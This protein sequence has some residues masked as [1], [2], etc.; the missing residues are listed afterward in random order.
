F[1]KAFGGDKVYFEALDK[2]RPCCEYVFER[3]HG[4]QIG[5]FLAKFDPAYSV[6][7]CPDAIR[8]AARES[9]LYYFKED[10]VVYIEAI[11]ETVFLGMPF[12]EIFESAIRGFIEAEKISG[13]KVHAVLIPSLW[14]HLDLLLKDEKGGFEAVQ[15]RAFFNTARMSSAEMRAWISKKAEA[16]E[17]LFP[18]LERQEWKKVFLREFE[19]DPAVTLES[20]KYNERF[21]QEVKFLVSV[22][23]FIM[24]KAQ[25]AA[26]E[27]VRG[28]IA[29][30]DKW[31]REQPE[32]A[33]RLVGLDTV[34]SEVGYIFWVLRPALRFAAKH[35]FKVR[36][37]LGETWPRGDI[38][39][40]L[41]R[42][43]DGLRSGI[44]MR[45]GHG[46]AA[47]I[48][49]DI[50]RK[51]GL[52]SEEE[53]KQIGALQK[54]IS[55]LANRNRVEIIG[56]P[57]SNQLIMPDCVGTYAEYP[58]QAF[59]KAFNHF[60]ISTDDPGIFKGNR[61]SEQLAR[62]WLANPNLREEIIFNL[63]SPR[64][65]STGGAANIGC[66][67]GLPIMATVQ[68]VEMIGKA[69]AFLEAIKDAEK[70]AASDIPILIEGETGVGKEVL[71][72][73][74]HDKSRRKDGPFI[75]VDVS[76]LGEELV[77]SELFGHTRGA[78][79]GA[80]RDKK[81]LVEQADGGTLFLDEI[82]NLSPATQNKLLHVL[83]KGGEFS[84]VGSTQARRSNFRLITANNRGNLRNVAGGKLFSLGLYHRVNDM[85]IWLPPLR[86]RRKDIPLLVEYFQRLLAEEHRV[87]VR[88]LSKSAM[89]ELM[90]RDWP[91]NIRELFNV[92]RRIF[93]FGEDVGLSR[94][95]PEVE[96][97]LQ[98]Q[99]P[100]I[101]FIDDS[102]RE[103]VL[104][105][106]SLALR[107]VVR[108]AEIVASTN[109]PVLI[110]GETG[111]GKSLLAG[112]IHSVSPRRNG[113]FVD[114]SVSD[115]PES[116][117][118]SEMF[119]HTKGSFTGAEN[120]KDGL[121]E[122]AN[123]GTLVIDGITSLNFSLQ[124]KL[125]R[126]FQ[127]KRFRRVGESKERYSDFRLITLVSGESM[128]ELVA[129][130]EFREDLFYR[131]G[132]IDI[133]LLPLRERKEDL[134]ALIDYYLRVYFGQ[135]GFPQRAPSAEMMRILLNYEWPGNVR[136]LSSIVHRLVLLD[137]TGE[138]YV[139]KDICPQAL[140]EASR[141]DSQLGC[142]FG[143][144]A[145]ALSGLI[146]LVSMGYGFWD[147]AL[148]EAGP[149]MATTS[150]GVSLNKTAD[151]DDYIR[152]LRKLIASRYFC[153]EHYQKLAQRQRKATRHPVEFLEKHPGIL[154]RLEQDYR[155]K[156]VLR[157]RIL[158]S[159]VT[160][161]DRINIFLTLD[162]VGAIIGPVDNERSIRQ[163]V[164]KI[165]DKIFEII[166]SYAGT[167]AE[168][169]EAY[170]RNFKGGKS[171][172]KYLFPE[173]E[174]LVLAEILAENHYSLVSASYSLGI[175]MGRSSV[176]MRRARALGLTRRF[177]KQVR[178]DRIVINRILANGTEDSSSQLGCFFGL[179]VMGVTCADET[180]EI[181]FSD[182][183]THLFVGE[184]KHY[185]AYRKL[186][187]HPV[188][189]NREIIGTHF[190]VWAPNAQSV[191]IVGDFNDW[192]QDRNYMVRQ[193]S[194][195][196]WQLFI[197][198]VSIG[199]R[200]KYAIKGSDGLVRLKNDPYG[201]FT[202]FPTSDN[203]MSTASIIWDLSY[204]W[205]D[206]AWMDKR[207]QTQALD[208]PVSI[209][210]VH[211]GSWRRNEDG[212]WLTYREIAEQLA[213]YVLQMGFTHVELLP[214][215]EYS[216]GGSWGYQVSNYFS[217]TSRFGQ[218]QDF[219]YFVDYLH[220][221]GI[222]VI[223]DWVPAHFPEDVHGL[224]KFDGTELYSHEYDVF[225]R[226]P[227][228]GTRI[229][230]YGR[231]EVKS[232]LI[233]NALFWLEK[234]H[235]DGLRVD[236][237]ASMLY[238][239]Y[240]RSKA[241][242]EF[243]WKI[244]G[245]NV[246]VAAM[247][248]LK[249]FNRVAHANF[250]GILTIA[251]EST[252]WAGVSRPTYID[253]LGFSMKWAMGWMHDVLEYMRLDPVHRKFHQN[254]ITF[255]LLYAF[256]ENF[257][258][259]LSHDEVVHG[260]K[261]LLEKMPG[262]QWQRFANLRLLFGNMFTMPGKN[263]IFMGG[264]F[265]QF[266]EW[267]HNLG[268]DWRVLDYPEHQ[269]LKRWVRD[270]NTLYR[271]EGAL[272]QRDF[273]QH[274]FNWIDCKDR[275]NSVISFVRQGNSPDEA[276]AIV[277]NFTPEPRENYRVGLPSSGIWQ[278]VLNSDAAIYG[279]SNMGNAG[280]VLAEGE[281]FH[282]QPYSVRL[283]LPPLSVVIFKN[284]RVN[285][286]VSS[287]NSLGCFFGLPI[288]AMADIQN[289]SA[290]SPHTDFDTLPLDPLIREA[291][292]AMHPA[293]K[294]DADWS[295]FNQI[296]VELKTRKN[297]Q[298]IV[299][300]GHR[301]VQ[302][303][304]TVDYFSKEQDLYDFFWYSADTLEARNEAY[305]VSALV[306][307]V[308]QHVS[309]GIALVIKER[310]K[311]FVR[312]IV[313]DNGAG[314]KNRKARISILEAIKDRHSP[315]EGGE[316]G[317]D[318]TNAVGRSAD[319]S[320]IE[321]PTESA[322]ISLVPSSAGDAEIVPNVRWVG[323]NDKKFGTTITGYFYRGAADQN[324][325]RE[326]LIESLKR[327]HEHFEITEVQVSEY[328]QLIKE[329]VRLI[330][331]HVMHDVIAAS[332]FAE[333]IYSSLKFN[334]QDNRQVVVARVGS[335][336]VIG[337]RIV[338]IL[339]DG[340]KD[341]LS[342]VSPEIETEG[343]LAGVVA[344]SM[345][346]KL[347]GIGTRLFERSLD[348]L[349][350]QN[351]RYYLATVHEDNA[352]A[353]VMLEN[354]SK[355]MGIGLLSLGISL[356]GE[357]V[358]NLFLLD[359][360]PDR[361]MPAFLLSQSTIVYDP[362]HPQTTHASADDSP[363]GCFFGMPV[364]AVTNS[365]DRQENIGGWQP[366]AELDGKVLINTETGRIKFASDEPDKD[367]IVDI[368]FEL[369]SV[370][371]GETEGNKRHGL[372]QGRVDLGINQ[373]NNKGRN[374][375]APKA[376]EKLWAQ[377][378]N[379]IKS[380]KR[381]LIITSTLSRSKDTA[382]PFIVLVKEA[383]GAEF[384]VVEE[385]LAD[386]LSFGIWENLTPDEIGD[387][388]GEQERER[389]ARY[390]RRD[391]TVR[392]RNG[393]S[394][395][396]LLIRRRKLWEKI[397]E[398]SPDIAVIF[399][400]GSAS[401]A[402]RILLGD[403]F[404]IDETGQLTWGSHRMPPNAEPVLFKASAR[405]GADL[406]RKTRDN[407]LGCFFG[408]PIMAMTEATQRFD[409]DILIAEAQRQWRESCEPKLIHTQTINDIR[410]MYGIKEYEELIELLADRFEGYRIA[411]AGKLAYFLRLFGYTRLFIGVYHGNYTLVLQALRGGSDR[412]I[413]A[414][415]EVAVRHY[416][417][418]MRHSAYSR[419]L[420]YEDQV[421]EFVSD[422]TEILEQKRKSGDHN[423]K[424]LIPG[425]ALAQDILS[426][427]WVLEHRIKPD[428]ADFD[429]FDFEF[430]CMERGQELCDEVKRQFSEGF[431][432]LA[433]FEEEPVSVSEA[434]GILE[435]LV[436]VNANLEYY[437]SRIR[438]ILGEVPNPEFTR[439]LEI[440]DLTILNW[441]WIKWKA[442][443][444]SF[445]GKRI[446][447]TDVVVHRLRNAASKNDPRLGCFFGLPVMAVTNTEEQGEGEH[448][449]S[450]DLSEGKRQLTK[451]KL[452]TIE[453]AIIRLRLRRLGSLELGRRVW[454]SFAGRGHELVGV[455]IINGF[456]V[457][458]KFLT[459]NTERIFSQ[460]IDSQ[461][462]KQIDAFIRLTPKRLATF[463]DVTVRKLFLNSQGSL[464]L[465]GKK[466]TKFQ[467]RGHEEVETLV[468]DG[469]PTEIR[470]VGSD[471]TRKL[472]LIY[473]RT[474]GK[475][476][477]S[478]YEIVKDE[479]KKLNNVTIREF[480]RGKTGNI[481]VGARTWLN[482]TDLPEDKIEIDV[483]EGIV[484]EVRIVDESGQAKETIILSLVYERKSGRLIDCFYGAL[485][486]ER[487]A[488]L[489]DHIIKRFRLDKEGFLKIGSKDWARFKYPNAEV[490][491][492]VKGGVVIK[493]FF[494]GI[495]KSRHLNLIF[496][497]SSGKLVDSFLVLT[498]EEFNRLKNKT[499]KSRLDSHGNL[500]IGG[501]AQ[502]RFPY[503]PH[504]WVMF[505][506]YKGKISNVRILRL[507]A[508]QKRQ[509]IYRDFRRLVYQNARA[510]AEAYNRAMFWA[511]NASDIA[512]SAL[513]DALVDQRISALMFEFLDTEEG[514]DLLRCIIDNFTRPSKELERLLAQIDR[515]EDRS[516]IY[517]E[518]DSEQLD[519]T[520]EAAEMDGPTIESDDVDAGREEDV[521]IRIALLLDLPL[522]KIQEEIDYLIST[523]DL[524]HRDE[525]IL[526]IVDEFG[527]SDEAADRTWVLLKEYI[528][529]DDEET[530][531]LDG[532]ED[533]EHLGC[534]FGLPVMAM[535]SAQQQ[536]K[537][538][539]IYAH[540]SQRQRDL[541]VEIGPYLDSVASVYFADLKQ[542]S[543]VCK[544][545]SI[546]LARILAKK[547][548]L[549]ISGD[550]PDRLEV[551]F[552]IKY[553]NEHNR[554]MFS[555][556]FWLALI[557]NNQ[558][559]I[560]IDATLFQ[561][562]P[563][564][565]GK[566]VVMP[567]QAALEKFIIEEA[568]EDTVIRFIESRHDMHLDLL[569][570]IF[571]G[572]PISKEEEPL[573]GLFPYNHLIYLMALVGYNKRVRAGKFSFET[574]MEEEVEELVRSTLNYSYE[575]S[576]AEDVSS[577]LGCFFGLPVMALTASS[578]AANPGKEEIPPGITGP[579]FKVDILEN[580][581]DILAF[582]GGE[583]KA[584]RSDEI[585]LWPN[586][587]RAAEVPIR[588]KRLRYAVTYASS[589]DLQTETPRVEEIRNGIL[590]IL[591]PLI[592]TLEAALSS[593]KGYMPLELLL[594][595]AQ[596]I[597]R[598]H[599]ILSSAKQPT[600]KHG[601]SVF[602]VDL[603]LGYLILKLHPFVALA[604]IFILIIWLFPTI[605][606][607]NLRYFAARIQLSLWKRI[608][609][610]HVSFLRLEKML[611][612][613]QQRYRL[614]A[615]GIVK[616]YLATLPQEQPG[617]Y[618]FDLRLA[619]EALYE[620]LEETPDIL[621]TM[622]EFKG[623]QGLAAI[624]TDLALNAARQRYENSEEMVKMFLNKYPELQ[625]FI[626]IEFA[627][628]VVKI[629]SPPIEKVQGVLR[630]CLRVALLAYILG[631]LA[632]L[633]RFE[634][635]ALVKAAFLHD[636]GKAHPSVVN[637]VT[638]TT[639]LPEDEY[640]R[641]KKIHPELTL[642]MVKG[643]LY[644]R[645]KDAKK[646]K[647][648]IETMIRHHHSIA[649]APVG[650]KYLLRLLSIVDIL[651]ASCDYRRPYMRRGYFTL[652][653]DTVDI[654]F[655]RLLVNGEINKGLFENI[656]ALVRN[657]LVGES[658]L[659]SLPFIRL[660][661]AV[662]L[663]SGLGGK[664][665][666]PWTPKPRFGGFRTR[667][668]TDGRY[669]DSLRKGFG[670][671]KTRL[672]PFAIE[673]MRLGIQ[674]QKS[675]DAEEGIYYLLRK[676]AVAF[677]LIR[678]TEDDINLTELLD[679]KHPGEEEL[680]YSC[681]SGYINILS[682]E[683]PAKA[684]ILTLKYRDVFLP[685]E[686]EAN[687]YYPNF[688][689]RQTVMRRLKDM[690]LILV[691]DTTCAGKTT[692]ATSL[693]R[694]RPSSFLVWGMDA[695]L[696][697]KIPRRPQK[698]EA[699]EDECYLDEQGRYDFDSPDAYKIE[700]LV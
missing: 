255:Y 537:V 651:D 23:A 151:T 593:G 483:D 498:I 548:N 135:Y 555:K 685:D 429:N 607:Q 551:V 222:G 513:D 559:V 327:V 270:L 619:L 132:G 628:S 573:Q 645:G 75:A 228:W 89:Q 244:R 256:T 265:A 127:N 605:F 669:P 276:L 567:Y 74:I 237:V 40:A 538:G 626:S 196:V 13:G 246:N 106:A 213:D 562:Y 618:G 662:I 94:E 281:P 361:P 64:A 495:G 134:P 138:S 234:Y 311:D 384:I 220:Q 382:S 175:I 108:I 218:P 162:E 412:L 598:I 25:K 79:T 501:K 602:L 341:L 292:K 544:K 169:K 438:F 509:E 484:T 32:L 680:F 177:S 224:A 385:P 634:L 58:L 183:D 19:K 472:A 339:N 49:I 219:M 677:A 446:M 518:S 197:P 430:I 149:V 201:V 165:E 59:L 451:R 568:D 35:G 223:I 204:S 198:N 294:K 403:R 54:E 353:R 563:Q 189:I 575:P 697:N 508:E 26:L 433:A 193:D 15:N 11:V 269:G 580:I 691:A 534:F 2:L 436:D 664:S 387:Y 99:A 655:K 72:R 317:R 321:Q 159:S 63:I 6:L 318:L 239:D 247:E 627:Q 660:H 62:L 166:E 545:S 517:H 649:S 367:P 303:G 133:E 506:V 80:D 460:V 668:S 420:R 556:H 36:D 288:M 172:G 449:D 168:R 217:P 16:A 659:E 87:E 591:N 125:L 359:M 5:A 686:I 590:T 663:A 479:F 599:V 478:F 129:Q 329:V 683:S 371:H 445:D 604:T 670:I 240:S 41:V 519:E 342:S 109:V 540:L 459:D 7:C 140:A 560:Y 418:R 570:R 629:F 338:R 687:V 380:G 282:G 488:E 473:D 207:A 391:A 462:G 414:M 474:T 447:G 614:S 648:L 340:E 456:P 383:T 613:I 665:C 69:P 160:E 225:G 364:M 566:I 547:F 366:I 465:G 390:A 112:Y 491:I 334:P 441:T 400:H 564:L 304:P 695:C 487:F 585:D 388:Y 597:N 248:L 179:P 313:I 235:I 413:L 33:E 139:L 443:G 123:G 684:K 249:E 10:N 274:G 373:L 115:V 354:I 178:A 39:Q 209:Y 264:E 28:F 55:Q 137:E 51:E 226:H 574:G 582:I 671:S 699:V 356:N 421:D 144:P 22:R 536:P 8:I 644:F 496:D 376:A 117:F 263:L 674:R 528:G 600:L 81:G 679:L 617:Y 411:T 66:F 471:M 386:E 250:P 185:A 45:I 156:I 657:K 170:I 427:I 98:A 507:K 399:N 368:D 88:P 615:K 609:H 584:L 68:E 633:D 468:K 493:V 43:R 27:Q 494:V 310:A 576:L 261:S 284:K 554:E 404:M 78:F 636:L 440:A 690:D 312:I 571:K 34:G 480:Y 126:V 335:G 297:L 533:D 398:L 642:E 370:R 161:C 583:K 678:E 180:N 532:E 299:I 409:D 434:K 357:E 111:T 48:P 592:E 610:P 324:K 698:G 336:E 486:G 212:R 243:I 330:K 9:A 167:F 171:E 469:I 116:L 522:E 148:R 640:A 424:I 206:S 426:W 85:E 620:K 622:A 147:S 467:G 136:Q 333:E 587:I 652:P 514:T 504:N 455:E 251:E 82:Q 347:R 145:S 232:F 29:I 539:N 12:A 118:E 673:K 589:D 689:K 425:C 215:S 291:K 260:K 266:R 394:F 124:A 174:K 1:I 194:S 65:A 675:E 351:I 349:R 379:K 107:R 322:I 42:M 278:E 267:N 586:S 452:A 458:I 700:S 262:D 184:G 624:V 290:P 631:K 516:W 577:R 254:D 423:I 114:I 365:E 152:L 120:D 392:P 435:V 650:T 308:N 358:L 326:E 86:K 612:I 543:Y 4:P 128:R 221:K 444:I 298:V 76:T 90:Q 646:T 295:R 231:N 611:Q 205:N 100:A 535:T 257:V 67:F 461:T 422:I 500:R 200:Y 46:L 565:T 70:V 654:Y 428:V 155:M 31:Q 52:Y 557:L 199:T 407:N 95:I 181:G 490:E 692:F 233:S 103:R 363:L 316:S 401:S 432:I 546:A 658:L 523:Q 408:L 110:S 300:A 104:V 287:D 395:I 96:L 389:S 258:L 549:P 211:L 416:S 236:A 526:R 187:A 202:E 553:Y 344:R 275:D 203:P 569:N 647:K 186:G 410:T 229:F 57:F 641:T 431:N 470:L 271:G 666:I 3:N 119:G 47:V 286:A 476:C 681:L 369:W 323:K 191:A 512:L 315:G 594:R 309:K 475:L 146:D 105:G 448:L 406:G 621:A 289:G 273:D 346:Y 682:R 623:E 393:E 638:S 343:V 442:L 667:I 477:G 121:I 301:F 319:V 130:G 672:D 163:D 360:F 210:E 279:G 154:S 450:L 630:H 97:P 561:F 314:F 552:G 305:F 588:L 153:P 601:D 608:F 405:F 188:K 466:V 227:D 653:E 307:N 520:E 306:N 581:A 84:P 579:P 348:Y 696:K 21:R 293:G 497:T 656:R 141:S 20:L 252:A 381:V 378:G 296:V 510:R 53:L 558:E 190:A 142:F 374:I 377:I 17:V 676:G 419:F 245:T 230:N 688:L 595:L 550:S 350:A 527:I 352:P 437:R 616:L 325:W 482:I 463:R 693:G 61:L 639:L 83:D 30:K 259:A 372:Y 102:G 50:L 38:I 499:I 457:R 131:I 572:Q 332:I 173:E 277:C 92:V 541:V 596:D 525:F 485:R 214:V 143:L 578:D 694:Q 529:E 241:E 113:P 280:A 606:P 637:L 272:H 328:P 71:A 216:F 285:N 625:E 93:V 44:L 635:E 337:V 453:H 481:S 150:A 515:E 195:G 56:N 60:G 268:L 643:K 375:Q 524:I 242:E 531:Y 283:T 73:Y 192:N 454:A 397:K 503:F 157:H 417:L 164:S 77:Q 415:F 331:E 492:T 603:S 511:N 661:N 632:E 208:K 362:K 505:D 101:T 502:R 355:E 396:D 253:G 91:G 464:Y 320:V 302:T 182:F 439:L 238:L 402:D 489:N 14:K 37:H 176:L 122:K 542:D 24:M 530:K 18:E 521:L 158:F 345:N